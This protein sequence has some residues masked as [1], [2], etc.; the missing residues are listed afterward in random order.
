MMQLRRGGDRR[1][2][3]GM[4]RRL[5]SFSLHSHNW[6]C[7]SGYLLYYMSISNQSQYV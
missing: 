5:E 2:S 6:S 1:I 4:E 7:H 3:E